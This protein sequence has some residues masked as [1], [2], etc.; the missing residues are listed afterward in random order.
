MKNKQY[1]GNPNGFIQVENPDYNPIEH[2]FGKIVGKKEKVGN[3]INLNYEL[4]A[5]ARGL[6][7]LGKKEKRWLLID[8]LEI[9]PFALRK[10]RNYI[11]EKPGCTRREE[12]N[13][14]EIDLHTNT[15]VRDRLELVGQYCMNNGILA[16]V[17]ERGNLYAAPFDEDR[18]N[19]L[20]KANYLEG[21]FPVPLSNWDSPANPI[22]AGKFAKWCYRARVINQKGLETLRGKEK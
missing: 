2:I 19:S 1:L 15:N 9:K 12:V 20:K 22:E 16:F 5:E 14:L 6:K 17:D 4:V 8:G 18:I 11:H 10:A 3:M 13:Y 7:C 21:D